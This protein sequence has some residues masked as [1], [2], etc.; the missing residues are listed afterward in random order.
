MRIR[1]RHLVGIIAILCHL[2]GST[3][4]WAETSREAYLKGVEDYAASHF[5]DAAEA[6][7][8][9]VQHDPSNHEAQL[10]LA[11]TNEQLRKI[12]EAI[13]AYQKLE[14]FR[15]FYPDLDF[16]IAKL[17]YNIQENDSALN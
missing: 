9:A 13:A 12:P 3:S 8:R 11:Q 15:K 4:S 7:Q 10:R 1:D 2:G 5:E 6:F 14:P 17:Y 16:I